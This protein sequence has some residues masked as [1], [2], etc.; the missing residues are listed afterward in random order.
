ML[1]IQAYQFH[2]LFPGVLGGLVL[3][4]A[5]TNTG[6][7]GMNGCAIPIQKPNDKETEEPVF[8]EIKP[9]K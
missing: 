4:Q 3:F 5:I 9:G 1:V 6:C 7:C 8:E 2:D